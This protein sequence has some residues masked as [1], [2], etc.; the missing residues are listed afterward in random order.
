VNPLWLEVDED[1]HLLRC[2][3]DMSDLMASVDPPVADLQQLFE[4]RTDLRAAVV[5]RAGLVRFGLGRG[6]ARVLLDAEIS[7]GA[8]GARFV[9]RRVDGLADDAEVG[10]LLVSHAEVHPDAYLVTDPDGVVLWCDVG[11]GQLVRWPQAD[12]LRRHRR[13]FRSPRVTEREIERHW[14]S[15]FATGAY[16]GRTLMRRS[17]GVDVLVDESVSAVRDPDGRVTHYV[18]MIRDV[19]RE[20]ETERLRNLDLSMQ[21]LGG[22]AGA[23]AHA[24]N[25]LAA[26]MLATCE[27]ALLSDDPASAGHALDRVIQLSAQLG[28]AGRRLLT[29][30]ASGGS[31]GPTDLSRSAQDLALLLRQSLGQRPLDADVEAIPGIEVTID[32]PEPGPRVRVSPEAIL[33]ASVH[34]ALR[35]LDGGVARGGVHIRVSEDYDEGVLHIAYEP[36]SLERDVLR[37]LLPDGA[38]TGP[39]GNE[40]LARAADGGLTLERHDEA[41]GTVA[42]RLRA[43]LVEDLPRVSAASAR[44]LDGRAGRVLIAEDNAP[45]RDL[46]ATALEGMFTEV[47]QAEDGPSALALLTEGPPFDLAVLDLKLPGLDGL[48]VLRRALAVHPA[49]RVVVASGAVPDGPASSATAAGARAVLAKPF[50]LAELRAVVR[51]VLDDATW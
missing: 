27:A 25:G 34:L 43:P 45:L 3:E 15:L 46:I 23:E 21:L 22:V 39:L 9:A 10:R 49:L 47:V 30:S 18:S 32:A 8:R 6:A 28:E 29:L 14:R 41:D 42:I 11:F 26:E 35:A 12:I 13:V 51:S 44:G 17:D 48:D 36:T 2:S 38:L 31:K 24:I 40:L 4:L 20:R 19:T 7:A 37:W 5:R 33:R 50:R 1:G 16:S